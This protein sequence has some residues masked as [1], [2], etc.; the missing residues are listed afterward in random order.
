MKSRHGNAFY[1]ADPCWEKSIGDRLIPPHPL[2][3]QTAYNVEFS[4][5]ERVV[6]QTIELPVIWD[7]MLMW[8]QCNGGTKVTGGYNICY[9][10]WW[11]KLQC[12]WSKLNNLF[13]YCD[14]TMG[15]MASHI[16]SLVIVYST[17]Y[18]GADQR[19]HQ[20]SAS[21][22]FVRGIHRWPVNSPHKWPVTQKMFNLMTSSCYMV[23]N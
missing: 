21:L 6:V 15:S 18:S 8:G 3:T 7:I 1:M 12:E 4:Y 20:S 17:V 11:C 9:R 2:P 10:H 19:K 14:V 5:P 22:A 13:H 23:T 16:T